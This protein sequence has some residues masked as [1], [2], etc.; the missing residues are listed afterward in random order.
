MSDGGGREWKAGRRKQLRALVI[1]TRHQHRGPTRELGV[2][3]LVF[4][5]QVCQLNV[6]FMFTNEEAGMLTVKILMKDHT[7]RR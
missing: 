7:G 3:L 4:L 5:T 1:M 6:S 2:G